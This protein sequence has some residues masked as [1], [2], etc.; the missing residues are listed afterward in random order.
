MQST[1]E[2]VVKTACS[3]CLRGC[4]INVSV[5]G[6]KIVKIEGMAEHPINHGRLCPKGS[7]IIDYVYSPERIKY[8]MKRVNGEF[9]R[10]SWDEALDTIVA[11]L[12][13]SKQKYGARGLAVC[14]GMVMLGQGI[15]TYN[16]IRRVTDVYGTPNFFSVDSM[17]FRP[18]F[19]GYILTVGTRPVADTENAKCIL[20]WGNNPNASS[21]VKAWHVTETVEKG[22]RLIA[23]DPRRIPLAKKAEI[24]LQPRP[25][26]DCAL[27]LGF[28]NTIIGEKLYDREFVEKW[29][30]GFD[31]LAEHVKQYPPEEVEKITWVPAEDIKRVARIFAQTKP[32]CILQGTNALDQTTS[33]VQSSRAI[34]ILHAITGNHDVPGGFVSTPLVKLKNIRLLDMMEC[35]P[36]GIDRYPLFYEVHGVLLAE[37]QG[38]TL[39]DTLL[40][41]KPYPIKTLFICGSN[42]LLTWPN[43]AKVKEA[44]SKV[45]FLMVMALKMNE[46]AQIADMVLPAASFIE[47][48][49]L[50]NEFY[51]A[52]FGLPFIMLRK[53]VIEIGECWS[54]MKFWLELSKRMGYEEYIPW[55]SEEE[56]LDNLLEPSGLTIKRLTE[57]EPGGVV[58]DTM[59][60]RQYEQKG[61][62]T[63]SRKVEIY[64]E[65]LEKLGHD[66]LPTYREPE[67]STISR[68]DLAKDYPLILTT[69]ARIDRYL[70]SQ[71]RDIPRLRRGAPN[72]VA[73]IHSRT[74]AEYGIKN[75]EKIVVETT[76]GSIEIEASVSEDILNK[77]VNIAHGWSEANVNILTDLKPSDP[78]SGIPLYK[79]ML[80]NTMPCRIR[81]VSS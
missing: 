4:G 73:E 42:P 57:D 79:S 5:V 30:V 6:G 14:Q 76:R 52:S 44:F 55:N 23:I 15:P 43:S 16:F 56:I 29:T 8:P 65:T 35:K 1:N 51:T 59:K 27:A 41:D 26:T 45:D 33:G 48:L 20:L 19:M 54:D 67:E 75:G 68:P 49:T 74:A 36:L 12:K 9:V 13:E 31:K 40:T 34:A 71:M 11:K 66:P 22:A 38:M 53:K 70:H 46:T 60:Y 81:K 28:L 63:P 61:F 21:P 58:Y 7:A 25:G 17:C 10:I 32:A 47:R 39:P 18:R 37:G 24:H 80:C 78:I 64:S 62:N 3:M 69:G 77:V 50:C 2:K 72:P